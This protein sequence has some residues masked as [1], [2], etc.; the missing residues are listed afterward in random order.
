[1]TSWRSVPLGSLLQHSVGGIWGSEAGLDDVDVRV[2]R[3]TELK[4]QGRLDPSTAAIRSITARQLAVRQLQ[5][6]DLLLEKSGGGPTTPVGRVGL[7]R[8]LD[9][10]PSVCS[11]FMQLMRPDRSQV[12]ARYLHLFLNFTHDR[13][14]TIRLQTATTNIRN[15]KASEYLKSLV[16]LPPLEEQRSIVDLLEDHLSRLDAASR[17]VAAASLRAKRL[18]LAVLSQSYQLGATR[19]LG[20]LAA[21]QGGIQ[22]QPKRTPG[23]NAFP[24]LRVAN[25]TGQGLDLADVHRVE[26]FD[27]ELDKL[28]LEVGDLLVVE[29]NGSPS[30]IGRAAL[31]DGSIA[32]SVHQNH[33]IR[34]RPITDV[35][36]GYLE[37]IW[38]SPQ[39]RRQLTELS[40]SSSGLHT[41]SVG[42]LKGPS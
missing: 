14:D 40:S 7:V 42:K 32:D 35:L 10:S 19:P 6:D 1:M 12:L 22:K 37:A 30:Q 3:V 4:K 39:N 24:F 16:V 5:P 26:L 23:A 34:V 25:V 33:L 41:L 9:E 27:G 31:W 15:I 18:E 21:I 20:T 38:N 36:P 11:N 13:G 28:R 2:L 29:G 8:T 17:G